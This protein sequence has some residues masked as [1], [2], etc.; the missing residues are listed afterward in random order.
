MSSTCWSSSMRATAAPPYLERLASQKSKYV[1]MAGTDSQRA[2]EDKTGGLFTHALLTAL[3]ER[4]RAS[5]GQLITTNELYSRAKRIV[6]D[7][8][9]SRRLAEQVPVLKDVG[10]GTSTGEFVFVRRN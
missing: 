10:M 9:R 2:N 3:K 6:L 7:E 4:S 8:V 5:D 1:L